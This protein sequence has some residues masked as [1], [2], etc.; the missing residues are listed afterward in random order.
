MN[1]PVPD[2]IL[3]KELKSE[4]FWKKLRASSLYDAELRL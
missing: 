1:M 3:D 2:P 4:E